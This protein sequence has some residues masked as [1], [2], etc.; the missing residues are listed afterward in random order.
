MFANPPYGVEWKA[1]EDFVKEEHATQGFNGRF[2]PG[3]PRVSDGSLL[4]LLHL[5]SKMQP[6]KNG[7]GGSRL[8]MVLN[9]SPL[10]TGGAGSGESNIR[11]WIIENDLLDTIVALR[12]RGLTVAAHLT[13]VGHSRS[14]IQ[15]LADRYRD[16]GVDH[17]LALRGDPPAGE[18]P[19]GELAHATELVTALRDAGIGRVAVAAF[20]EGHPESGFDVAAEIENLKRKEAAGATQAITQFCLENDTVLRFVDRARTAG[21]DL[22]IV[23]GI[24]PV[25]NVTQTRK[26]ATTVGATIPA[27]L[28]ELFEGLDDDPTTR[29]LV[30]ASIASEQ[31]ADLAAHGLNHVHFYTLNRAQ[32]TYAVC[33]TLGIRVRL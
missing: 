23:P 11:Q 7:Q 31:C 26:F 12:S 29:D 24:L 21:I 30:A 3:L 10:F 1:Q 22:E 20:P 27:W 18:L 2:G 8:A 25:S 32:L 4:F 9:G 15:E 6:V 19:T 33:R 14:E 28:D 16:V 5:I 13:C 17:I